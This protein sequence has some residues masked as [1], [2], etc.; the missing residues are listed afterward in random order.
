MT[1]ASA[2]QGPCQGACSLLAGTVAHSTLPLS[3]GVWIGRGAKA[4]PPVQCVLSYLP[5]LG[6]NWVKDSELD[7]PCLILE[8]AWFFQG[9][10]GKVLVEGLDPLHWVRW[11]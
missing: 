2:G 10:G 11:V 8:P 3:V 9:F 7:Q 1:E 4:H 5:V 6:V